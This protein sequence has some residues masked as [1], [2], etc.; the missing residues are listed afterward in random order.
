MSKTDL[1]FL[2]GRNRGRDAKF[3]LIAPRIGGVEMT[4]GTL[5]P[6]DE[7]IDGGPSVLFDAPWYCSYLP[8]ARSNW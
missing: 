5:V 3:K 7:K 4:D 8:K 6:A 1:F 2:A